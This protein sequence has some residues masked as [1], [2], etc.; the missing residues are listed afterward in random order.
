M[1]ITV[2][3]PA[4]AQ[5]G[6]L[7]NPR[8]LVP[9]R[10]FTRLVDYT[11]EHHRVTR[12]YAERMIGQAL[13]FLKVIATNPGVRVVPDISVDP[14]WHAFL[15]HTRQYAEFE[16]E[17]ND[18][19]RLHHNPIMVEDIKSGAAMERTIPLLWAS[20]YAVDMEF[21]VTGESS[22]PPNPPQIPPPPSVG[23][24]D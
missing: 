19:N 24:A 20:G 4:I 1:T 18:G 3:R 5:A 11:V 23:P 8:Q 15:M 9:E 12:T 13:I 14:G 10:T 17:H 2:D 22:C 21:W 16:R 6:R 7:K